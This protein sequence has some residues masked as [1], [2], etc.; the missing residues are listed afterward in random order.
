M[1]LDAKIGLLWAWYGRFLH[2]VWL[3]LADGVAHEAFSSLFRGCGD[4]EVIL[5]L[6]LTWTHRMG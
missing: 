4:G 1:E 5:S 3:E 6:R 2:I